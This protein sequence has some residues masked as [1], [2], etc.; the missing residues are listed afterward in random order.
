MALACGVS[1]AN[2]YFPQAISPLLAADLHVSESSAAL[3]AT[4]TQ[5]GYAAG[6][7]LLVPLGDRL[8]RRPLI[9]TLMGVVAVGLF[10]AG[11]TSSLPALIIV[12]VVVGAA[13]VV[14]QMLIPL[15]A[16]LV[17]AAHRGRI[18]GVLQG[19]LLGGILLARAFGG[20][21]GEWLGWRAP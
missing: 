2:V 13:T 9:A 5:L 20:M 8:P 7:F 3:V 21:V 15:A 17:D 14:P 11:S 6:I 10:L 18:V 1:V 12:S 4:F 16:D 19:G